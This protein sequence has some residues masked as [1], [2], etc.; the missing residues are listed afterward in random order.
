[1]AA[2]T[3]LV[4]DRPQLIK[5]AEGNAVSDV[6]DITIGDKHTCILNRDRTIQCWG[7]NHL[8]QSGQSAAELV[9]KNASTDGRTVGGPSTVTLP[10]PPTNQDRTPPAETSPSWQGDMDLCFT[11]L[12]AESVS[13][14]NTL[15]HE[16]RIPAI[17]DPGNMKTDTTTVTVTSCGTDPVTIHKLELGDPNGPF[18]VPTLTEDLVLAANQSHSFV[19]TYSPSPLDE[20]FEHKAQIKFVS[21]LSED[22]TLSLIGAGYE[23]ELC[24]FDPVSRVKVEALIFASGVVQK[25][26]GLKACNGGRVFVTGG[27]IM[28]EAGTSPVAFLINGSSSM[29]AFEIGGNGTPTT[30]IHIDF[31]H[32]GQDGEAKFEF[33]TASVTSYSIHMKGYAPSDAKICLVSIDDAILMPPF[34]PSTT[35]TIGPPLRFISGEQQEKTLRIK[36]CGDDTLMTNFQVENQPIPAL[37]PIT[38]SNLMLELEPEEEADILLVYS[39]LENSYLDSHFVS[40]SNADPQLRLPLEAGYNGVDVPPALIA[41]G[42]THNCVL[43]EDAMGQNQSVYCWGALFARDGGPSGDY[44]V[45]T[46]TPTRIDMTEALKGGSK[47]VDIKSGDGFSCTL[48]DANKIHCWGGGPAVDSRALVHQTMAVRAST[49][50]A[51]S[52]PGTGIRNLKAIQVDDIGDQYLAFEFTER[53]A[54]GQMVYTPMMPVPPS[55]THG[56][57]AKLNKYNEVEW[58]TTIYG[59]DPG[60]INIAAMVLDSNNNVYVAGSY[61]GE[62]DFSAGTMGC[63]NIDIPQPGNEAAFVAKYDNGGTCMS[64]RT[65][66]QKGNEGAGDSVIKDLAIDNQNG[67]L[68]AVG[69]FSG[70]FH[71]GIGM[72]RESEAGSDDA[73]VI[74]LDRNNLVVLEALL[75]PDLN[76]GQTGAENDSINAVKVDSAGNVIFAGQFWGTHGFGSGGGPSPGTPGEPQLLIAKYSPVLMPM[77]SDY[78]AYEWAFL[79]PLA[80]CSNQF[81]PPETRTGYVDTCDNASEREISN[82]K[83][84]ID[85]NDDIY[86]MAYLKGRIAEFDSSGSTSI[87]EGRG[88]AF[89]TMRHADGTLGN[90]SSVINQGPYEYYPKAVAYDK[91]RR[92]LRTLMKQ[93]ARTDAGSSGRFSEGHDFQVY[94]HHISSREDEISIGNFSSAPVARYLEGEA[95]TVDDAGD[96]YLGGCFRGHMTLDRLTFRTHGGLRG[97]ANTDN[98]VEDAFLLKLR[99]PT[100]GSTVPFQ[101]DFSDDGSGDPVTV[102]DETIDK[103][104]V[105]GSHACVRVIQDDGT[106]VKDVYCWG[107]NRQ[108]QID[109]FFT[110]PRAGGTRTPVTL[111]LFSSDFNSFGSN[112]APKAV[113][114]TLGLEHSC[115]LFVPTSTTMS[116]DAPHAW[117]W[118]ECGEGQ[119]GRFDLVGTSTGSIM[120]SLDRQDHFLSGGS[121]DHTCAI[122]DIESSNDAELV[123]WGSNSCHQV[124]GASSAVTSSVTTHVLQNVSSQRQQ[125]IAVGGEFTCH[126]KASGQVDCFGNNAKNQLALG[127]EPGSSSCAFDDGN[128][129]MPSIMALDRVE[130]I[131]LGDEHGCAIAQPAQAADKSVW[132]WGSASE[133]QQAQNGL[134]SQPYAREVT[135]PLVFGD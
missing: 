40:I 78:L 11:Q 50:T 65:F 55:V 87:A 103:L 60:M 95:M 90:L 34:E 125:E 116:I 15:S 126:R 49:S 109:P 39:S 113:D 37:F 17:P 105:G 70:E 66:T 114:F 44:R 97:P 86:L 64:V 133:G 123:C 57:I 89:F 23:D 9:G 35:A 41:A 4:Y 31:T 51:P 111:Q 27:Q 69:S 61:E 128:V 96:L 122:M 98:Q 28:P 79:D 20:N 118:G 48:N 94:S 74:V 33:T 107:A 59:S 88:D 77:M 81:P 26:L 85:D 43:R 92:A 76:S 6:I 67:R 129:M 25:Q 84:V 13:P 10:S 12:G 127:T 47:I 2:P 42:K 22:K 19:I 32:N 80:V 106:T 3:G 45:A 99:P 134:V 93:K 7:L 58:A 132:C 110:Q 63:R 115:A 117:C 36:N 104:W 112:Q 30:T 83:L 130:Q 124:V 82:H 8:G 52:S 131:S 100:P 46:S 24:F 5:G 135:L 91:R 120:F 18:T 119:C 29:S 102:D 62:P 14:P 72:E 21:N 38:P 1:M 16:F 54:L 68:Y 53:M 108:G 56:L 73:F 121:S 75:Y 101:I 71:P